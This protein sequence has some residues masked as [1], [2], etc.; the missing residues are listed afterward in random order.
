MAKYVCKIKCL[1]D[2]IDVDRGYYQQQNILNDWTRS[3][4]LYHNIIIKL[5]Q[6]HCLPDVKLGV[7]IR[8]RLIQIHCLPNV[9]PLSYAPDVQS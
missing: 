7:K 4:F 8:I 5:I 6:I 3:P 2:L 1:K 9:G